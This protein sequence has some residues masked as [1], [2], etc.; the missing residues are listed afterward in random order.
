MNFRNFRISLLYFAC[1]SILKFVF[2]LN[3]TAFLS[4]SSSLLLLLLL[5]NYLFSVCLRPVVRFRSP[6][7]RMKLLREL[8]SEDAPLLAGTLCD[9]PLHTLMST[10]TTKAPECTADTITVTS[11]ATTTTAT[12]TASTTAVSELENPKASNGSPDVWKKTTVAS[13]YDV[14]EPVVRVRR[15]PFPRSASDSKMSTRTR[16]QPKLEFAITRPRGSRCTA[17]SEL[18]RLTADIAAEN[19]DMIHFQQVLNTWVSFFKN[20]L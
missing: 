17:V 10:A 14:M 1:S 16:R 5:F 2:Y 19:P 7:S 20:L 18:G 8:E 11:S 3:K 13:C 12:A 9:A 6:S 15:V 4:L